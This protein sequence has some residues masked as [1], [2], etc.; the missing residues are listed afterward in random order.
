[1][2]SGSAIAL[3]LALA[4]GGPAEVFS[5]VVDLA[6][7]RGEEAAR[8]DNIVLLEAGD[9]EP[10]ADEAAAALAPKGDAVAAAV[11]KGEAAALAP[12]D[13][14]APA[15]FDGVRENAVE[16][17]PPKP[18]AA[19]FAAVSGAEKPGKLPPAVLATAV[20]AGRE[21]FI[22]S[23]PPTAAGEIGS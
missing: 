7:A 3:D 4:A 17:P 5:G 12:N 21:F 14:A 8:P 11:P 20:L 2:A 16:A 6:L 10:N 18:K 23:R 13:E 22:V 19:G 9:E 15:G 1:M